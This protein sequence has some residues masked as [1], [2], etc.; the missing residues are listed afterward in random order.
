MK[1]SGVQ[2]FG[3][4]LLVA[5]AVALFG[6]WWLLGSNGPSEVPGQIV[7][8][9][10][11]RDSSPDPSR[12]GDPAA[13]V[14]A[15]ALDG[16][17]GAAASPPSSSARAQTTRGG[18]LFRVL[19]HESRGQAG[20]S[21]TMDGSEAVLGETSASGGCRVAPPERMV[22]DAEFRAKRG[23]ESLK[24]YPD[25]D[26]RYCAYSVPKDAV[27]V[28]VV[29]AD[30]G[31]PIEDA[32]VGLSVVS[33]PS[34]SA[35]S[36]T[37][38]WNS[39]FTVEGLEEDEGEGMRAWT[40]AAGRAVFQPVAPERYVWAT[41][42]KGG[43]NLRDSGQYF[44]PGSVI[45]LRLR[46]ILH[47]LVVGVG[48]EIARMQLADQKPYWQSWRPECDGQDGAAESLWRQYPDSIPVAFETPIRLREVRPRDWSSE[49]SVALVHVAWRDRKGFEKHEIELRPVVDGPHLVR[50]QPL[51]A[52]DANANSELRI[53]VVDLSGVPMQSV[54]I[55]IWR[56]SANFADKGLVSGPM[57]LPA[58]KYHVAVAESR[59]RRWSKPITVSAAGGQVHDVELKF[60]RPMIRVR[61]EIAGGGDDFF[62]LRITDSRGQRLFVDGAVYEGEGAGHWVPADLLTVKL[63]RSSFMRNLLAA[64]DPE[65]PPA[66]REAWQRTFDLRAVRRDRVVDLTMDVS[67]PPD[68]VK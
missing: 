37:D 15:T 43:Y 46:P 51:A 48:A 10:T 19:D 52:A 32:P 20:Y 35:G 41:V 31:A 58:G 9:A 54:E 5:V 68:S 59:L 60:E 64:P 22:A 36:M 18:L 62:Q 3:V 63:V 42:H 23:G 27:L 45:R 30:T 1:S 66:T 14:T 61:L 67:G 49:E 47:A 28:L 38:E 8:S 13:A 40:G 29:R 44:R 55:Q 2:N 57:I 26:R 17:S 25:G 50:L 53:K 7:A 33:T 65:R 6:G 11:E 24:F 39:A 12:D 56:S 21:I 4:V 16:S 34:K